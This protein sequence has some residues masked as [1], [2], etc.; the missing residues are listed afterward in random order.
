[1]LW[2]VEIRPL[3]RD[4]ERERVCDEFDLLTHSTRG[5]DLLKSSARGFLLEGNLD[6]AA[7]ERL[8]T[9]LL[10]DSVVESSTLSEVGNANGNQAITVLLKPGVMDP[11]AESVL[12]ASQD[13][14]LPLQAVRTFRRYFGTPD[15]KGSD[16]DLL[17]RK[18]LANDAIEQIVAGP[19]HADHLALGKPY[20]F[21]KV[22]VPLREL[23]DD[24]LM[25]LS[26]DGQ[27]ALNV[28]EMRAV[29]AH[30]RDQGREPT[31]VEL[32][33]IAQTWSE[34]CSHKTL[35]GPID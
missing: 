32:E 33:T 24:G 5:A 22:I 21:K 16:R 9:E 31:D 35:K 13:L 3:G 26:R 6:R 2:E 10:V 28:D 23:N 4:A 11:V 17:F 34:H 25:K 20:A 27:L 8:A 12:I 1:M 14:G 7:A 18:V 19:L 30:F 29:R 15:L